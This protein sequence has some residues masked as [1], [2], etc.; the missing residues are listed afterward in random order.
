MTKQEKKTGTPQ[1]SEPVAST[2]VK[3]MQSFRSQNGFYRPEDLSKVLGSEHD[4]VGVESSS[5][6]VFASKIAHK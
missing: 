5:E 2:W 6:L 3:E 1:T 4:P